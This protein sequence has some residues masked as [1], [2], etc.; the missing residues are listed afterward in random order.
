MIYKIKNN[1]NKGYASADACDYTA[2]L[3]NELQGKGYN[4]SSGFGMQGK[5]MAYYV[6]SNSRMILSL[7]ETKTRA[8]LETFTDCEIMGYAVDFIKNCY[9]MEVE[10]A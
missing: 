6:F 5:N 8:V 1:R 2:W 7:Y 10:R 4:V 9:A 3:K